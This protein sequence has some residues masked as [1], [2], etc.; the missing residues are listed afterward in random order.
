MDDEDDATRIVERPAT[1]NTDDDADDQTR[2]VEHG[3]DGGDVDGEDDQTRVVS[4]EGPADDDDENT[5][6]VTRGGSADDDD[7]TRVVQRDAK[8]HSLT[9]PASG[10]RRGI[11]MPPA[12]ENYSPEVEIAR[13]PGAVEAYPAREIPEPP[14]PP[15]PT[16]EG[17]PA[18]RAS[19]PSMPSVARRSR[20]SAKV[21]LTVFVTSCVLA[22]AGLVVGLVVVLQRGIN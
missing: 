5:R 20:R 2:V 4:H 17:P 9:L 16:Q 12:M 8:K 1:V 13:G 7:N 18:T 14:P 11:A 10:R 21:A 19:A 6:I 3:S 22:V 15:A